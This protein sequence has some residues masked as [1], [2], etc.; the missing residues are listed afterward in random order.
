V[1]IFRFPAVHDFD[2]A[3]PH[4]GHIWNWLRRAT[5][6]D[7]GYASYLHCADAARAFVLAVEQPRPGC[8]AYHFVAKDI[9]SLV[10][11]AERLRTQMPDWPQL[12]DTWP[13]FASPVVC[14]KAK[15]HFGWEAQF[16]ITAEHQKKFGTELLTAEYH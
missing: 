13:P 8:E 1:A 15:D 11:L 4:A 10:P 6:K 2:L 3:G 7:E 12:P 14:N 9:F 16:S 5:G